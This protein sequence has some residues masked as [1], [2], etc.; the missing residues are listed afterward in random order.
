MLTTI[1]LFPLIH[2][3]SVFDHLLEINGHQIDPATAVSHTNVS[4]LTITPD[5]IPNRPLPGCFDG[6]GVAEGGREEY[7]IFP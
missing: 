2:F 6:C 5:R 1:A 4:S 7:Q 3:A